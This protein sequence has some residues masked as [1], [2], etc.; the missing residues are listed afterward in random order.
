MIKFTILKSL[1]LICLGYDIEDENIILSVCM[2]EDFCFLSD[3]A[4]VFFFFSSI[5]I[6]FFTC[7]A[8][9][10]RCAGVVGRKDYGWTA[11]LPTVEQLP[12]QYSV[13]IRNPTRQRR[14]C[15]CYLNSRGEIFESTQGT[16]LSMQPILQRLISGMFI[17]CIILLGISSPHVCIALYATRVMSLVDISHLFWTSSHD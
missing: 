6:T 12:S 17:T 8:W 13:I 9:W 15:R 1:D 16:S 5:L 14:I 7:R 3:F 4:V 2:A 11:V 10:S